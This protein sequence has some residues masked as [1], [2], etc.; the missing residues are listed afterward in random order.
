[1]VWFIV[2][3]SL[4]ALGLLWA[5]S[6]IAF[7]A[8]YA[9]GNPVLTLVNPSSP[10]D[11]IRKAEHDLGLDLPFHEQY[12]RFVGNMLKGDL[13]SSYVTSQPALSLVLQR[14]P[15]TLELAI[16][17]IVIAGLVGIPLGIYA[18][19]RPCSV[20]G[21]LTGSLS[22][23]T[24]SLPSFVTALALIIVFGIELRIFPT[25]G[26][27]AVGTVLGVPTSFATWDGLRHLP[28]PAINLSLFPMALFARLTRS[29]VQETMGSTFI[30]F[31]R[32]KGLSSRRILS[33]YVLRNIVVPIITVMGIVFGTLLAF[34]V[35]TETIFS[36]PGTGKLIIDSIRS[37][38][39]PV[40]IAYLMFTAAIFIAINF[41]VDILCVLIDPRISLSGRN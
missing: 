22:M 29:G 23:L 35:V 26:R 8:I 37:S 12:F 36:W 27:G 31:A 11:V 28:M 5:M 21:R 2:R 40:I 30:R 19:Y 10:P 15:A 9:L 6:I 24:V 39:R 25:G 7:L 38:D 4:Q 41:T 1:M 3:R 13:G 20:V 18:G 32:A 17:A 34:S 14:F 33:V 16:V